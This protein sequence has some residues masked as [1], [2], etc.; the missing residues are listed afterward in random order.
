MN[1]T[2]AREQETKRDP[3]TPKDGASRGKIFMETFG[4]QMN[5]LDSELIQGNLKEKGYGTT[6]DKEEADVILYNT[7][8]VRGH[9]EQKALSHLGHL[10][11]LKEKKPEVVIGVVGCMAQRRG[12]SL[13]DKMPHIDLVCGTDHYPDL[14]GLIEDV[15]ENRGQKVALERTDEVDMDNPP[16]FRQ[17]RESPFQAYV[18]AMKGCGCRC[19]FCV[20]PATRGKDVSRH[21]EEIQEEIRE[22]AGDGVREVT[23]LGQNIT[24]YGKNMEGEVNRSG[25]VF[26]DPDAWDH[27][28][29]SLLHKVHEVPGIDRIRFVTSHPFFATRGLFQ[30]MA[31]LPKVM[32]Y[33]HIPAQS[34]SNRMLKKM[35]RGYTYETYLETCHIARE[36]VP[37]LNIASDFIVGF[38]G[39][40]EEDFRKTRELIAE[41]DIGQSYIFKYSTRPNTPAKDVFEDDVP[42]EV[43]QE[44]NHILLDVQEKVSLRRH[45]DMIG[46]TLKVLVEGPSKTD[47]SRWAGRAPGNDIVVFPRD[48][49]DLTGQLVDVDIENATALTLFGTR[50]DTD[51]E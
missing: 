48:G 29:E 3:D 15:R 33:L 8:S 27:N 51:D 9:A 24:E 34:G 46:D 40:T 4:C 45:M 37:D 50:A 31:D 42:D 32:P 11:F 43:K 19:T 7:C 35:A 39:E 26:Q 36:I 30:A 2:A 5:F 17:H 28:L 14:P 47:D 13:M 21:P 38:P 10:K 44:R 49:E 22:L 6:E 23:L 18:L 12:A 16:R 41:A 25:S 20:V 1:P